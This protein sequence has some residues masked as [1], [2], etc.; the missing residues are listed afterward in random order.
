MLI[1]PNNRTISVPEALKDIGSEEINQL[2]E[3]EE[4]NRLNFSMVSS[5]KLESIEGN[6]NT[7]KRI[8]KSGF[9]FD[10]YRVLYPHH[11]KKEIFETVSEKYD[12]F[13][14]WRQFQ[15]DLQVYNDKKS[16]IFA[17]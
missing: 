16:Y 4:N 2:R 10:V 5:D 7:K 8:Y 6:V 14:Y 17:S 9:L 1:L 15:R 3:F 11:S 12:L 13:I